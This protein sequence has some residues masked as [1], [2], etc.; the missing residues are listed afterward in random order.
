MYWIVRKLI[1]DFRFKIKSNIFFPKQP[2]IKQKVKNILFILNS[3]L[4]FR[5][6]N[7]I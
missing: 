6:T 7:E 1:S 3:N 5:I 4:F 2:N